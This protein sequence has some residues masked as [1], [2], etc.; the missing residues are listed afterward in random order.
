[1]FARHICV[2]ILF[3]MEH[4]ITGV[5]GLDARTILIICDQ[6]DINNPDSL[7]Q[8][9]DYLER[10]GRCTSDATIPFVQKINE[11]RLN[12][13]MDGV[14]PFC[15][16]KLHSGTV[17]I[18]DDC[19]DQ[20]VDIGEGY[21]TDEL[22][23]SDMKR[24]FSSIGD[25][26]KKVGAFF[27]AVW[28][29]IVKVLTNKIFWISFGACV[30]AVLGVMIGL[31]IAAK[32]AEITQTKVARKFGQ[33]IK[34]HGYALINKTEAEENC[35]TYDISPAGDS[36]V[37]FGDEE[38]DFICAAVS[39]NGSDEVSK[40][41]QI[42]LMSDLNKAVFKKMTDEESVNLISQV[43]TAEGVIVR[44]GYQCILVM[45]E[46]NI[47]YYIFDEN[48]LN[49]IPDA[50]NEIESDED[51]GNIVFSDGLEVIGL[52]YNLCDA[53]FGESEIVI[54]A[55]TLYYVNRGVTI[56][57]DINSGLVSYIDCDGTGTEGNLKIAGI[58]IGDSEQD[59]KEYLNN[60]GIPADIVNGELS[61]GIRYNEQ[62]IELSVSIIDGK[63]VYISATRV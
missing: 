21:E 22:D 8:V 31:L 56:V 13:I 5:S 28:K 4:K 60:Q 39:A 53:T 1:M 44:D 62:N 15:G 23:A 54:S 45:T 32:S 19:H 11:Y 26:F 29:F 6:I 63:V 12:G 38:G 55:N 18:C 2:I 30:F 49:K 40:Q 52:P 3:T 9:C 34:T 57:Y 48:S 46:N 17:L 35:I 47:I 42:T 20:L 27:A 41:R 14:C 16:E 24:F 43:A 50:M 58:S 33:N 7:A 51:D 36:F 59:V 10:K 25:F 37:V 61:V